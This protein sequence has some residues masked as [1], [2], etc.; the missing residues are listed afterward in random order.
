MRKKTKFLFLRASVIL[1]FTILAGKLWYV[2]VVMGSYYRQQGNTSKIRNESVQALRG[3]IYDRNGHQL[4]FNAPSWN[5]MIVPNAVPP[6][7]AQGIYRRLAQLLGNNPS[8]SRIAH[9]VD[10][11]TW[12][13]Y[14]PIIVKPDIPV[15]TA[16]VI[17][18]LHLQL[19]GVS[20]IPAS[21]RNYRLDPQMTLAHI[22]GY[23][24][25]IAPS[26]YTTDARSYPKE[27]ITPSDQVGVDGI[28]AELDPYLHGVNGSQAVEVD[29][30]ER[31][32]RVLHQTPAV[33]GDKVYL[34]IDSH[35]QR[36]VANDLGAALAK[37]QLSRGVVVVEKVQTGQI[38]AM[39]SLP[40]FNDNWFSGGINAKHWRQVSSPPYP[41]DDLA[42]GGQFPPGSIYKMITA[43][44]A[45]QT[46]VVNAATTYNDTGEIDLYGHIFRGWKAGGLGPENIVTALAQSSDI[47]FYTVA[48]GNP[49][50]GNVPHTGP[51]KLAHFARLFGLG[52][53]TGIQLPGESAGLIPDPGWFRKAYPGYLWHIGDTYNMAIGQGQNLVT[54]LQMAN[55][56][57][58]IANGGTLYRP[59]I[60][61]R[62]VGR[63]EPRQGTL[64]HGTVLQPFVP[65]I[66]RR[67]FV[68]PSNIALIQQGMHLGVAASKPWYGTSWLV[69]DPRIDAAGKTGTA[70]DPHGTPDAWWSGYAPYG[71][72]QIAVT[73]LIPNAGAEG[74]YYAAPI[75]HKILED[76]FHLKPKL[77][78]F[79]GDTNWLDD[80]Q[81]IELPIGGQ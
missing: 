31:P 65:S 22:L 18:M 44:A 6:Y 52:K 49:N 15:N 80:V 70:E 47:Y 37:Y 68:A 19:P 40:S 59:S 54:P 69:H 67:H 71:N 55:V 39:A 78:D 24:S 11:N 48:G 64:A 30:G 34:T 62:I 57:S 13:G 8:A 51:W 4:V 74:S 26:Q 42:V 14:H 33:P 5:A 75:A 36:Q 10:S 76:Y 43:A 28:E 29:S 63:V 66:I 50:A 81:Q 46:G 12:Q 45:L 58:A 27:H 20:A 2:Q 38:L 61:Q 3:I 1:A 35:F 23:T 73:V 21:V 41:L 16:L 17:R 79:P 7:R 32:V 56:T 77:P 60:I 53:P 9:I 72:P 25:V